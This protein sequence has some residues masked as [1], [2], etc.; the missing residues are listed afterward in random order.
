[1]NKYLKLL[2]SITFLSVFCLM[3]F[4]I[5]N[6]FYKKTDSTNPEVP[7]EESSHPN[8]SKYQEFYTSFTGDIGTWDGKVNQDEEIKKFINNTGKEK[9]WSS[10]ENIYLQNSKS[11]KDNSEIICGDTRESCTFKN[12]EIPDGYE[13]KWGTFLYVDEDGNQY[14]FFTE[15]SSKKDFLFINEEKIELGKIVNGTDG[16]VENVTIVNGKISFLYIKNDMTEKELQEL[17]EC[18]EKYSDVGGVQARCGNEKSRR[19]YFY[20]EPNFSQKVGVDSV[21]K[22]FEY[23]GKIG[24]IGEKNEK[25]AVYFD[26]Q[27]ISGDFDEIRTTACCTIR[28]F[29]FRVYNNGTI[30]FMGRRGEQYILAE[31][32][33]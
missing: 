31:S 1:M 22:I 14:N 2:I 16:G 30:F 17:Y 3:L 23:N 6:I 13:V 18:Y 4:G 33:L 8:S 5:H 10:N 11:L 29:P 27:K 12:V 7:I 9:F 25:W 20:G 32:L 19:E 15:I 21:S 24:F 26:G 28:T